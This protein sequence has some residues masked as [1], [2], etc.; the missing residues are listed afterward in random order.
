MRAGAQ[1]KTTNVKHPSRLQMYTSCETPE[2]SIEDFETYALDRLQGCCS[3]PLVLF[4]SATTRHL[5]GALRLSQSC[6][7]G[8]NCCKSLRFES[9]QLK[10]QQSL[11]QRRPMDSTELV[12]PCTWV[13]FVLLFFSAEGNR[14]R[15]GAQQE[16]RR[17]Q[18]PCEA[19]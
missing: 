6:H 9:W 14:D 11:T 3:A 5:G 10:P 2:I 19:D 15:Q 4:L 12:V 1:K 17:V 8:R 18:E 7:F 16:G 13:L